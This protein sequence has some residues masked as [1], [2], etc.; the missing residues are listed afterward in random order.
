MRGLYS[1]GLA[2]ASTAAGILGAMLGLGGGVFIV[3]IYTLFFGVPQKAAIAASAIAVVSNS[4]VGSQSHLRSGFT[5]IRL[6]MLLLVPMTACAIVGALIGVYAPD[7]LLSVLFGGV[8]IYAA[9]S[10]NLKKN[11]APPPPGRPDPWALGATFTDPATTQPTSYVPERVRTGLGISGIAGVFSGMLGV[12]GGVVMVP[13]M[14]LVMRVPLKA[15]AGTSAFMVGMTSVATAFVYYANGKV[16][17][18]IAVPA[19]VG[20]FFGG[21]FGAA[22]TRRLKVQSLT[23]VFVVILGFLGLWMIQS[24]A[25]IIGRLS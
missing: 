13:A 11:A 25:D 8:L 9:F 18:T 22:L 23:K 21:R 2:A 7:A 10:M 1:L 17:P 19:M 14:T 6:V 15:A 3:P 24:G 20:I 5:N 12:G 4:V 16:D